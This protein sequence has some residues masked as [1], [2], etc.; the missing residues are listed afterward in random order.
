MNKI[1]LL[2]LLV[3]ILV[4]CENP[5]IGEWERFGD[6]SEGSIIKIEKI[7]NDL[8]S[9]LIKVVGKLTELG[10]VKHDIKWEN[11]KLVSKKEYKYTFKDL[12][13]IT[14]D[15]KILKSGYIDSYF[16]IKKDGTIETHVLVEKKSAS[17]DH[18]KW[19]KII[20]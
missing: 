13:K 2:F 20:K 5:L 9:K 10:F 14:Y 12:F 18:Q 1:F 4:C 15:G 17:G 16:L 11:I 8:Q 6:E 19:K 7:G 3:A